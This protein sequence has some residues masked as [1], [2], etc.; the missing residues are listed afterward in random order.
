MKKRIPKRTS[1]AKVKFNGP[2]VGRISG[3]KIIGFDRAKE[4]ERDKCYATL[5]KFIKNGIVIEGSMPIM[6]ELESLNSW[7]KHDA[8]A[9]LKRQ[10][11]DI[12][13]EIGSILFTSTKKAE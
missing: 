4:S 9:I 7:F 13:D 2:I 8:E 3:L 5:V 1:P 6:D 11:K 12:Q 10:S